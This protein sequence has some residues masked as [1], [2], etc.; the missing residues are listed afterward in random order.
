MEI[1]VSDWIAIAS[2][3]TSFIAYME[4]KKAN[5]NN[6]SVAA[7]KEVLKASEKTHVYLYDRTQGK[8]RNFGKEMEIAHLWSK[9]AFLISRIDKELSVRLHAKSEF[10]MSQDTWDVDIRAH[11][12]IS[13]DS[14]TADARRLIEA[15]T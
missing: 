5:K 14:V 8:E 4:A 3:A 6:E 7:L 2:F 13:L 11:K 1:E 9:A 15:Y 12:D 10:W